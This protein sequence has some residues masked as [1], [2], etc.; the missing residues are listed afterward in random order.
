[1]PFA[2]LRRHDRTRRIGGYGS[3]TTETSGGMAVRVVAHAIPHAPAHGL[4]HPAEIGDQLSLTLSLDST[5]VMATE[6]SQ[7]EPSGAG[8]TRASLAGPDAVR[9]IAP[10]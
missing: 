3:A 10:N 9:R 6:R 7:A 4:P 2:P 1:M 8:R 5:I